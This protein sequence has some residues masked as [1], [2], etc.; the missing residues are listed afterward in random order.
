[1][2]RS[3]WFTAMAGLVVL[4]T[5]HRPLQCG[6]SEAIKRDQAR[7]TSPSPPRRG[8]PGVVADTAA[9]GS[10]VSLK[11]N[12]DYF[13]EPDISFTVA[14]ACGKGTNATGIGR[15]TTRTGAR[16]FEVRV[17]PGGGCVIIWEG[18]GNDA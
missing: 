11:G 17:C 9:D 13:F 2:R 10:C 5:A 6:S 1:M 4:A 3:T 7:E 15:S 12:W 18:T 16:D 14:T 8:L